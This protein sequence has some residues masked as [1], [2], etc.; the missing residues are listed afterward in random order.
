M[1]QLDWS[2]S[3]INVGTSAKLTRTAHAKFEKKHGNQ[4]PCM[5]LHQTL[6]KL[7]F[8]GK[9]W[10]ICSFILF[11]RLV[12][13]DGKD[14]CSNSTVLNNRFIAWPS[15]W[16]PSGP[17]IE[18]FAEAQAKYRAS[19]VPSLSD[20]YHRAFRWPSNFIQIY[21]SPSLALIGQRADFCHRAHALKTRLLASSQW[22]PI[23]IDPHRLATCQAFLQSYITWGVPFRLCSF[24]IWI[25]GLQ[26]GQPFQ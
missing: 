16:V 10:Q 20:F 8:S 13:Q 9:H 7:M 14:S 23:C 1:D 2:E 4:W 5:T 17:S 11:K 25:M 12:L 19:G 3:D 26:R 24:W 22:R 18:G 6:S 15:W 21:V